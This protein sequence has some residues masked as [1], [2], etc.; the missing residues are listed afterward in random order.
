MIWFRNLALAAAMVMYPVSAHAEDWWLIPGD[1]QRGAVYFAD[2]DS[3]KQADG[4][5]SLRVLRIAPS[6][7]AVE[8]AHVARCAARPASPDEEAL[9]HFACATPAERMKFAMMLGAMTPDEA[10]RLVFAMK[11]A[12]PP[13]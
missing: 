8:A 9:R 13:S 10:A 4:Q 6:G 2:A 7:E 3:L 1:F 11:A 5:A 12:N